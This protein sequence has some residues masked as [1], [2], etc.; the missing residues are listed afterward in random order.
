[1]S[2]ITQNDIKE[3]A[4]KNYIFTHNPEDKISKDTLWEHYKISN[5]FPS[6]SRCIFSRYFCSSIVLPKDTHTAKWIYG[7][8]LHETP[9]TPIPENDT[10]SVDSFTIRE[11]SSAVLNW[12]NERFQWTTTATDKVEKKTFYDMFHRENP[13]ADYP[14]NMIGLV[15]SKNAQPGVKSTKKYWRNMVMNVCP[16]CG[17]GNE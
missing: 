8:K 6:P 15:I 10:S 5:P 7:V 1:M 16:T 17:R 13:E 9:E 3:W 4:L 14:D 11:C 12:F 2:R